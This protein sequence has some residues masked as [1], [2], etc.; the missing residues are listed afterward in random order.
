MTGNFLDRSGIWVNLAAEIDQILL[1]EAE[2]EE[3]WAQLS[4]NPCQARI[5]AARVR[6]IRARLAA[7]PR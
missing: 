4:L 7:S 3:L 5:A 1:R 6:T 2:A